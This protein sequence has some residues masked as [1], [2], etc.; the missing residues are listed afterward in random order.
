M[1][2]IKKILISLPETLLNEVDNLASIDNINRSELIREAMKL[3]LG[4]RKR[5][6]LREKLIKGY[7]EMAQLSISLSEDCFSQDVEDFLN[8]E[9]NLGRCK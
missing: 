3:Y 5:T 2:E 6:E 8:Y 1:P 4:Q 9:K 7:Q